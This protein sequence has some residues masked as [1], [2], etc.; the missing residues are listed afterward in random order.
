MGE[1]GSGFK[2]KVHSNAVAVADCAH[3]NSASRIY[4]RKAKTMAE[5]ISIEAGCLR[6]NR[7]ALNGAIWS[8]GFILP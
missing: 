1:R 6:S 8:I 7:Q 3:R 2:R 5:E 4:E